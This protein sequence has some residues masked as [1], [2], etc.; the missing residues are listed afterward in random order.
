MAVGVMKGKLWLLERSIWI[1]WHRCICKHDWKKKMGREVIA[2]RRKAKQLPRV[3]GERE[4]IL[5][6]WQRGKRVRQRQRETEASGDWQR[7][8]DR[9][10]QTV[11]DRQEGVRWREGDMK[12]TWHL[13]AQTSSYGISGHFHL[14]LSAGFEHAHTYGT[15]QQKFSW[16]HDSLNL[17]D[18]I[19]NKPG[20]LWK[21]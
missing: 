9:E 18:L 5:T 12:T 4:D 6:N 10:V 11:T 1:I 7:Q 19:Y 3:T 16:Q 15:N 2:R 13:M 21:T 20:S 8:R 17:P 14:Q